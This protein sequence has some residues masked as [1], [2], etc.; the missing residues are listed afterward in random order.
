MKNVFLKMNMVQYIANDFKHVFGKEL[1]PKMA[2]DYVA[3]LE[4]HITARPLA[5]ITALAIGRVNELLAPKNLKITEELTLITL[6]NNVNEEDS[7]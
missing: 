7:N 6:N 1:G 5:Y 2:A 4:S 3:Y